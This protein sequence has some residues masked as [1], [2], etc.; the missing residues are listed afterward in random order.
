[1]LTMT[2]REFR[3]Y[4][5]ITTTSEMVSEEQS[6]NVRRLFYSVLLKHSQFC[7]LVS[8]GSSAKK[9]YLWAQKD[10]FIFPSQISSAVINMEKCKL[11]SVL[12]KQIW[13]IF[14]MEVWGGI[15]DGEDGVRGEDAERVGCKLGSWNTWVQSRVQWFRPFFGMVWFRL[16]I[17][18]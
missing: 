9:L 10:F 4:F 13:R 12:C 5:R 17:L 8:K 7:S 6:V 16:E 3:Q 14:H 11:F 1:M 18:T 15:P 2:K